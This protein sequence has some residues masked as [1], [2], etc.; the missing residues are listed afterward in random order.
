VR[1]SFSCG[2]ASVPSYLTGSSLIE[3]A[4]EALLQAKRE[5]RNQIIAA[6]RKRQELSV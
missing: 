5:G 6:G 3:A 1:A 4:D 2:V